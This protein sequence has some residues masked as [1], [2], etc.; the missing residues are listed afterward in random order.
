MANLRRI[1]VSGAGGSGYATIQDNGSNLPQETILNFVGG[2]VSIV[3]NPGVSTDVTISSTGF[4]YT[5]IT[6]NTVLVPNQGY[7]VNAASPVTLTLPLAF[8]EGSVIKILGYAGGFT[9]AQNV[10]QQIVW[11]NASTTSGGAGSIAS[12]LPS[13]SI[14]LVGFIANDVLIVS[15]AGGNLTVT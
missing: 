11:L 5:V 6:A 12:T 9:I 14:D 10:G 3:D 4:T 13:D 2:N 15:G 8:A 1:Q 7:I